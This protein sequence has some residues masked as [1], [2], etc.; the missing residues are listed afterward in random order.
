M[1]CNCI[2]AFIYICIPACKL[3][4]E[5]IPGFK[6][7]KLNSRK[8]YTVLLKTT[9]PPAHVED[10]W[11][12]IAAINKNTKAILALSKQSKIPFGLLA[13]LSEAFKCC[14]CAT[15]MKPPILLARCC[16]RILE[17]EEGLNTWYSGADALTKTCPQ[18]RAERGRPNE[19]LIKRGRLSSE[20]TRRTRC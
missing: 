19:P 12:E 1:Y 8:F 9:L 16:K 13:L 5:T 17:C 7:R 15:L 20:C 18:C 3:S 11:R 2:I 6:F 14:I 10:P 4:A